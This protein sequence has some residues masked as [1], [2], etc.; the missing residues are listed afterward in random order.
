MLMEKGLYLYRWFRD[1]S[2]ARKLYF[3]V[4]TMALLIGVELFVLLFSLNTLSSLRAYVGGEGLWSK[5]QKD[6]VFHLY[7][8][9]VSRA[10]K[11]Y[12]LFEQ[13]MRVPG[14]D[15]KTRRELLLNNPNMEAARQ[16]FLEGRNHPDDIQG[17]ISLFIDFGNVSYIRK[18]IAIWADAEALAMQLLP[19]AKELREQVNSPAPSQD[20]IDKLLVS[21]YTINEKLTVFEDEFS[22]TLGEGSRW[23]ERVVLKLLFITAL[24]VETTGLLL[25]VSV[26]R[27]IQKGL[28]D[29][30]RAAK[31]FSMGG[32]SARAMVLSRDE[33][34]TVANS[35]NEMADNLQM[36]LGELA[37]LNRHMR[38]EIGER[39]RAEAELRG[40]FALLDRHVNNTPL[41]VIEWEQ[42]HAA[43]EPPRVFRWSGRAQTIFGW[44]DRDVLARSADEFGFIYEGDA[45][46]VADAWLDLAEGRRPHNSVGL[47]C[48]TKERQVRHCQWYNSALRLKDSG[49][50]TILSLVEDITE[51]VAA[52]EE[53]H[54]LAHHDTLTGL[55]NRV[56]LHD[57]LNQALAGARRHHHSVAVM[58]V[59]LDHF[60]N[61]NDSLGHRIGD[62][63]LQQ[64]A[65][66][67]R[68]RLRE[69]DTVARV[70]GDEFVLIQTELTDPGDASVMAQTVLELLTRP[71]VVQGSQLYIDTSIG[72]TLFPQDGADSDLLLRNADLALYRAKREG[73]GQYRFYSRD[74]DQELRATLSIESGLRHAIDHGGLELFYQPTFALA[75]GSMQS[76]EA[77]IRWPNP[78]GGHLLPA[79]FIPIAEISGLIVPLG[80]W[81]LRTACGQAKAWKASG[82]NLRFAVNV[83]AVQLRQPDFAAL[84]ERILADSG[85]VASA[86]ELE[87]TESV[88]LDPSKVVITKALN[89]VAE[90][91][92]TLAIDDFGTGYSSLGYL[93]RFPFSR[94]KIDGSF[95]RDID[96]EDDSKA[97]VKAMIALG[98]SLG[99]SVTAEGVETQTQLAFLRANTC[100]EVQGYLLARPRAVGEIEQALYWRM[101]DHVGPTLEQIQENIAHASE[102]GPVETRV[103]HEIM[104]L[105]RD[106][107]RLN[108]MVM[109]LRDAGMSWHAVKAAIEVEMKR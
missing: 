102:R 91:G 54:R 49:K 105:V 63:L 69:T 67:I 92:V 22:F 8:Y 78:G 59:D 38:H 19:L 62:A 3:T 77:L 14:G 1:I 85:L 82:L 44:T 76:V 104:E 4:G 95:V 18:A 94:I 48:Y 99:K 90:L 30:I 28:T 29:I 15:A 108:Q 87:V 65:G 106:M 51:R 11:D 64:V 9:G 61:V 72:I 26:S 52:E 56:L 83:S 27:G 24:T 73:R 70:G 89:E 25:T 37:Q 41:A 33:I 60:K 32:L 2:I 17:M 16:G 43:G 107:P 34:G 7:R 21:I 46:R 12:E 47:R 39:E 97:I 31:S 74:M 66:R 42:D 45:Q 101:W 13:F 86:L 57:R 93:K 88:F 50:V 55:P 71:F 53:V 96:S 5:A 79:S 23:L 98:H 80:E 36:R 20:R 109:R 103:I 100:D 58:M 40:A 6:A 81:V 84:V 35:F 68:G 10:D 75:D